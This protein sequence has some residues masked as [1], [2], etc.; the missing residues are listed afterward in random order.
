MEEDIQE[1]Q[2]LGITI[3]KYDGGFSSGEPTP[4]L[5]SVPSDVLPEGWHSMS[6]SQKKRVLKPK[7]A[8]EGYGEKKNGE[9]KENNGEKEGGQ[10]N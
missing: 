6:R 9:K 7:Q 1:R 3:P 2:R 4:D 10:Q 8:W 5:G